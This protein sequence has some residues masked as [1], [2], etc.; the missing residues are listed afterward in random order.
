MNRD[1]ML[2]S[3]G[4]TNISL[5]SVMLREFYSALRIFQEEGCLEYCSNCLMRSFIAKFVISNCWIV[6]GSL[7]VR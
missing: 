3:K 5:L 7:I 6:D 1:F 4:T 2:Q